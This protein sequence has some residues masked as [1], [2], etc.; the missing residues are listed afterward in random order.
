MNAVDHVKLAISRVKLTSLHMSCLVGTNRAKI[1]SPSQDGA[2][3]LNLHPPTPKMSATSST[4]TLRHRLTEMFRPI[5][6]SRA[7]RYSHRRE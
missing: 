1:S 4:H 6:Q 7:E 2:G 3:R 5:N